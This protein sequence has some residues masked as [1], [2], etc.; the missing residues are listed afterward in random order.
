MCNVQSPDSQCSSGGLA[1]FLLFLIIVAAAGDFVLVIAV[2]MI[3]VF[4][5]ALMI[6]GISDAF[7]RQRNKKKAV[8]ERMKWLTL[9]RE[10]EIR[11]QKFKEE[12]RIRQAEARTKAEETRRVKALANQLMEEERRRT[13]AQ[14]RETLSRRRDFLWH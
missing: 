3:L 4:M 1:W 6:E 7:N 2:G 10:R 9:E 12:M 11:W 13:E 14:N 8:V 5:L